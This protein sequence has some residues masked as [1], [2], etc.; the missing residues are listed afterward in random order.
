MLASKYL[1]LIAAIFCFLSGALA[2][3]CTED[4]SDT[5]CVD[6][7]TDTT[8]DECTTTTTTTTVAPISSTSTTTTAAPTIAATTKKTVNRKKVTI[9]NMKFTVK[10]KIK[11]FKKSG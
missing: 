5:S 11:V 1:I 3:T 9:K 2:V 6:C 10:R 7:T 4:P 8:N